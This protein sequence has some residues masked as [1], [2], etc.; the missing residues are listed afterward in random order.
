MIKPF[1]MYVRTVITS[2]HDKILLLKQNRMDKK[3]VWDLPRTPLTEEES[4]DESVTN[5]IQ[6]EIGY[7]VYPGKIIGVSEYNDRNLSEIHVLMEGFILNGELILSK[8]YEDYGWV[9]LKRLSDYPLAPW[10]NYYI[11][12][13]EA[14]FKDVLLEIE[15]M[16][17]RDK[18]KTEL[19]EENI[20][21]QPKRSIF[22]SK[23]DKDTQPVETEEDKKSESSVKSS[24]KLLKDTIKRTF[25]PRQ[26]KVSRT[27]PKE[28]PIYTNDKVTADENSLFN[29]E[30]PEDIIPERETDMG[31]EDDIIINHDDDI[32]IDHDEDIIINHDD[33]IIID[34]DDDNIITSLEEEEKNIKTEPTVRVIHE[35]ETPHVRK[36]NESKEKMSF[37]SSSSNWKNKINKINRT[38]ANDENRVIPRPKGRKK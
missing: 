32:I 9:S 8:N 14:P 30:T 18:Q 21:S 17:E 37:Y 29:H 33:D 27:Q 15:N 19:Y 11:N 4:F 22:R 36:I 34:H 13:T 24:F 16:Q 26:A 38:K 25:H 20:V 31:L 7:Y 23:K 6:K 1:N 28:N 10:L 3:A 2:E 12:N 35:N 5:N